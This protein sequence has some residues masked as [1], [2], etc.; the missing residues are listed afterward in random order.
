MKYIKS[1]LSVAILFA[2]AFCHN[3]KSKMEPEEE[4]PAP[5]PTPSAPQYGFK[6][7]NWW[8]YTCTTTSTYTP[9]YNKDSVV[10]YADT[11]IAGNTYYKFF[12][13][14]TPYS[15]LQGF[16]LSNM[17][18]RDSVNFIIN[19]KGIRYYSTAGYTGILSKDTIMPGPYWA[20]TWKLYEPPGTY[21]INCNSNMYSATL[22]IF[23]VTANPSSYPNFGTKKYHTY[24][25]PSLGIVHYEFGFMN[26]TNM[27]YQNDLLKYSIQ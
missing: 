19:D 18:V 25:T 7:G 6:K 1:L 24:L 15:S 23:E 5:A 21:S 3:K 8:V 12:S 2:F 14:K 27:T 16:P 10:I 20:A 9:P 22:N 4:S 11:L 13:Y 26:D 17:W